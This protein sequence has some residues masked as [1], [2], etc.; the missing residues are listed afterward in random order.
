[1]KIGRLYKC[2]VT[3]QVFERIGDV[4]FSA[5]KNAISANEPFVLLEYIQSNV[6]MPIK[7]LSTSGLMGWINIDPSELIDCGKAE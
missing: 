7:V 2:E 4:T 3:R 1:M 6:N 5:T